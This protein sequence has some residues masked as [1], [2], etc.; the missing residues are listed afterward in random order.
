M[1]SNSMLMHCAK[2]YRPFELFA[3]ENYEL[4]N[5][6]NSMQCLKEVCLK[7]SPRDPLSAEMNDTSA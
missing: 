2:S 1:N 6:L 4:R 5:E 7:I 3:N